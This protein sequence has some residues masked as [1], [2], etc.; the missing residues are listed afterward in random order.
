MRRLRA[1]WVG[2]RGYS[3]VGCVCVGYGQVGYICVGYGQVGC[4]CVGCEQAASDLEDRA[5][6][7][8]GMAKLAANA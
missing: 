1:S 5:K 2:F 4:V 8:T 3:Q 7:A 6:L